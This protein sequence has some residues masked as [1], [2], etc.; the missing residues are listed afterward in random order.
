MRHGPCFSMQ[1]FIRK[2]DSWIILDELSEGC[3]SPVYEEEIIL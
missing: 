3:G 1:E 2:S